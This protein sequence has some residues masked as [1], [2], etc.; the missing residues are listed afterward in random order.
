MVSHE[1]LVEVFGQDVVLLSPQ[2][3]P[4]ELQGQPA[5]RTL[6]HT[7]L[8]KNLLDAISSLPDLDDGLKT[9]GEH[10]ADVGV[11]SSGRTQG[12]YRIGYAG[13]S[14]LID[15]GAG[16]IYYAAPEDGSTLRINTSI[17]KYVE[18][19]YILE[20]ERGRFDFLDEEDLALQR[21][22]ISDL[23]RAV[24][25]AAWVTGYPFWRWVIG[26]ISADDYRVF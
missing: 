10:C 15:P 22:E 7:G 18:A 20:K 2:A 11:E 12:M 21:Q 14:I 1:S 6:T 4:R 25:E 24:D 3:V 16:D 19:L 8:P 13:G 26:Q 9:Y 5:G 23:L 17:D